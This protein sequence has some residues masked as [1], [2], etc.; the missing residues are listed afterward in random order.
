MAE[1]SCANCKLRAKYD[2]N[3]KS[4]LGRLWHWHAH[5]CPGFRS[6]MLSLS[7]T[8]RRNQAGRY[9]LPKYK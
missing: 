3:P 8:E 1:Q 4:L 9:N 6:Y 7:D 2:S 5:W